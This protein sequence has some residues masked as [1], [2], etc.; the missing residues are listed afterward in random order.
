MRPIKALVKGT[1]AHLQ[2]VGKKEG[3]ERG[4]TRERFQGSKKGSNKQLN[5]S[6]PVWLMETGEVIFTVGMPGVVL[7]KRE[8]LAMLDYPKKNMGSG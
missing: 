4:K 7:K 3:R 2:T 8:R 5:L 1:A 6:V